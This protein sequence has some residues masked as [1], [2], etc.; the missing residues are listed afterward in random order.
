MTGHAFQAVLT[1]EDAV[2]LLCAVGRHLRPDGLL[3]AMATRRRLMRLGRCV[4]HPPDDVVALPLTLGGHFRFVVFL[5]VGH[6]GQ[7]Y[8]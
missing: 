3:V 5:G 8:H 1:D 7:S 2:A 4:H 6:E